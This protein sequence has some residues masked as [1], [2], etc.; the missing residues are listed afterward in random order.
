VFV[1]PGDTAGSMPSSKR[2]AVGHGFPSGSLNTGHPNLYCTWALSTA[3]NS[4][5][6]LTTDLGSDYLLNSSLHY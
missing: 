5:Y 4:H 2:I 6:L 1:L 3:L